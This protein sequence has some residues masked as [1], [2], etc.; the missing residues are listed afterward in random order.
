MNELGRMY[1]RGSATYAGK[2][3]YY[4]LYKLIIIITILLRHSYTLVFKPVSISLY[5]HNYN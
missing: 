3:F 2:Y 1:F 5:K 4:D